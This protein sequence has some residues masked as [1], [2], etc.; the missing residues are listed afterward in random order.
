MRSGLFVLFLVFYCCACNTNTGQLPDGYSTDCEFPIRFDPD[1]TDHEGHPYRDVNLNRNITFENAFKKDLGDKNQYKIEKVLGNGTFGS[2][3]K[4]I[5]TPTNETVALKILL[6]SNENQ[7]SKEVSMLREMKDAP[8]FLQLRDV[9][10]EVENGEVT[11]GLV[12]DFFPGERFADFY[13]NLDAYEM[14]VIIYETMRTL[15][16]AHSNGVMHRD[17]KPLN[18]LMIPGELQ[19]RVIDWGLAEFY[20]P[21]KILG[22]NVGTLY[23]KAPELLLGYGKYDYSVDVWSTGCML[24]EMAFKKYHFFVG[25]RNLYPMTP[26]MPADESKIILFRAQLDSYARV[27]GTKNLRK[28]A[29]K[30]K[31]DMLDYDKIVDY[32]IEHEEMPLTDFINNTNY[33]MVDPLLIDLLYKMLVIDHTERITMKEALMHPYFDEVRGQ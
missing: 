19:V 26:D 14:K 33:D 28:Y 18:V 24:A 31:D 4:A 32:I 27:L 7:I 3:F 17:I 23:Y 22:R 16:Y 5:H 10:K 9:L 13:Q 12:S 6:H 8:N 29:D 21:D 11:F 2:V 15:E 30:F 25:N 20:I 1:H